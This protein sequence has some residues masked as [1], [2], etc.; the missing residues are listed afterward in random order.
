EI[1]PGAAVWGAD[2]RPGVSIPPLDECLALASAIAGVARGPTIRR[3][4]ACHVVKIATRGANR[5]VG[6]WNDNPRD[7]IPVLNQGLAVTSSILRGADGPAI[8]RRIA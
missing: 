5:T 1:L 6:R 7:P 3:R 4:R 8:R 2:N